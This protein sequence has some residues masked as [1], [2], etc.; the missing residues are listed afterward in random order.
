MREHAAPLA[1]D[2][3]T[4]SLLE[5]HDGESIRELAGERQDI[6]PFELGTLIDRAITNAGGALDELTRETALFACAV[7]YAKQVLRGTLDVRELARWAHEKIGH[8]GPAWG[9]ALVVLDDQF[10]EFGT[11]DGGRAREPE[12]RQVI[13][14]LLNAHPRPS[15]QG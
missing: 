15:S 12:W 6:S 3:A 8:T 2:A 11:F 7:H 5:G 14:D 1:I 9:E 10:D 4:R 13:V